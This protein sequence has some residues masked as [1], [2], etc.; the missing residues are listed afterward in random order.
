LRPI[1]KI[2]K[3]AE[4]KLACVERGVGL[5]AHAFRVLIEPQ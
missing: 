3:I 4:G 5:E 1:E 2:Y